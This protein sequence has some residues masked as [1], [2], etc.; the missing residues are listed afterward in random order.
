MLLATTCQCEQKQ[1]SRNPCHEKG[2]GERLV[3]DNLFIV[4]L[5]RAS[6]QVSF[7]SLVVP[8]IIEVSTSCL[9]TEENA[10]E[11]EAGPGK[12]ELDEPLLLLVSPQDGRRVHT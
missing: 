5:L 4:R 8:L 10:G 1:R 2:G 3:H 7:S 11:T 6:H 9:I 12:V